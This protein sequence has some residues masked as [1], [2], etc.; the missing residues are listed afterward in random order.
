M[1]HKRKHPAVLQGMPRRGQIWWAEF[2]RGIG[3][4]IRKTR[5]AI[6]VSNDHSNDTL[7]RVQAVPV[8]TNVAKVFPSEALVMVR[9]IRCKALADQLDTLDT[10]RLLA[11][12]GSIT[13]AEMKDLERA[14]RIQLAL[15]ER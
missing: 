15:L 13:E 6:I 2:Q 5:P 9:N 10:S 1:A 3:S 14:I 8:T 7:N 4:E 11:I 12:V